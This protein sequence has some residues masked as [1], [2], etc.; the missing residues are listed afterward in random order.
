MGGSVIGRFWVRWSEDGRGVTIL[1]TVFLSEFRVS[2]LL[3]VV[4][5]HSE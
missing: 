3:G 4:V 2:F 1:G 5:G